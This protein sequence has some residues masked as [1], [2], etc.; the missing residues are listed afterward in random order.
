MAVTCSE[1]MLSRKIVDCES[2]EFLY[3]VEGT[4][5]E[6]AAMA[7][8]LAA[9]PLTYD[10]GS[11]SGAVDLHRQAPELEPIHVDTVTDTGLWEARVTYKP[12]GQVTPPQPEES[13]FSFD[14]TGGTQ[15]ITQSRLTVNKYAA[16]GVTPTDFKGA[17]GY[18]PETNEVE[19]C[20]IVVPVYKFRETH[21]KSAS[22]VDTA[23]KKAVMQLTGK[24]NSAAF[25]GF[26]AGEVLF[27]G[28]QGQ[29]RGRHADDLWELTFE[30]A[31]S[32]NRTNIVVGD[33]TVGAKWGW[34]HM[35]VLYKS[36][37]DATSKKRRKVPLSVYV[38][39]VY[40]V[41]SFSALGCGS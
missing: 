29:R 5:S 36:D 25:K 16:S 26:E 9:A 40:E 37:V 24:V 31:V 19:G 18:N 34:E 22:F 8:V 4:S 41:A 13:T 21:Y 6:T 12:L 2:A 11:G 28:C 10:F 35:W 7:A 39:K 1:L 27:L 3:L 33:V 32:E 20:E 30:F 15:K 17:I 38:E 23:Y 14:T